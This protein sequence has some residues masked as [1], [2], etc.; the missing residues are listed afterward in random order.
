MEDDFHHFGVTI[1]HDGTTIQKVHASSPRYPWTTCPGALEAIRVLEGKPLVARASDIGQLA[2]MRRQCTH[3]FDLAGLTLAHAANGHDHRRYEI[4]IPDRAVL[5]DDQGKLKG[6]GPTTA[7]LS[8]E[9]TVLMAWNIDGQAIVGPDAYAGHSLQE[10]F[11]EWTEAMPLEEAEYATILRRAILVGSGRLISMEK[12]ETA[13]H[14]GMGPVCF[15]YQ[16]EQRKLARFIQAARLDFADRPEDLLR[17][18]ND[19]P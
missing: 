1:T 15:T 17:N 13:E 5:W 2:D 19:V 3:L 4:L 7:T 12:V 14:T 10:G 6:F 16:P 18:V 8:S 11:R 9:G